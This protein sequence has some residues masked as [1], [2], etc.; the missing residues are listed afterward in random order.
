M[1]GHG[2]PE[3]S[4]EYGCSK[5]GGVKVMDIQGRMIRERERAIGMTDTERAWRAKWVK[6]QV[7]HG[8]PIIPDNWYQE[9]YNPIRRF[10]R[11]PMQLFQSAL[12]PVI[13]SLKAEIARH[14]IAKMGFL[15]LGTYAGLYY[16]KY[17]AGNWERKGGW[18]VTV[19]RPAMYPNDK[20]FPNYKE[21]APHDYATFGF[22][23]SSI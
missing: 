6:D 10:Y 18:K 16:F 23:K 19:N 22:E 15:I 14:F 11:T 12:T 8:E 5:S 7:L 21:T 2:E 17:N 9:R 1:G 20:D 13:G 4:N 3:I